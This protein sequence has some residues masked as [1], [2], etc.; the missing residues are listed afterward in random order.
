[1][2]R[3]ATKHLGAA[4][5]AGRTQPGQQWLS[6]LQL[7]DRARDCWLGSAR[8]SLAATMQCGVIPARMTTELR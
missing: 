2:I 5:Q 3:E 4:R 6:T 8:D 1:M 7:R